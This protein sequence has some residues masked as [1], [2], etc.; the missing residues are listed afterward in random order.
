M[1]FKN[2]ISRNCDSID[3]KQLFIFKAEKL[4]FY[5]YNTFT[6]V[7]LIPNTLKNFAKDI[8]ISHI[9]TIISITN[10]NDD[11]SFEVVLEYLMHLMIQTMV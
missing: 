10:S 5:K 8:A 4:K 3:L 9:D 1:S 2:F 6:W 11:K 7:L